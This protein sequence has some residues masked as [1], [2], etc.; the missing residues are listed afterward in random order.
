MSEAPAV[1]EHCVKVY[2]A[3]NRQA[4]D[5]E[6]NDDPI[7]GQGTVQKF[8]EGHTTRLFSELGLAAPYYTSVMNH[9]KRMG[10]VVQVR[11]GGGTAS[12]KWELLQEP[13]EELYNNM[14]GGNVNPTSAKARMDFLEKQV[15]D[16]YRRQQL[17]EQMMGVSL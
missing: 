8:W 11:R 2:E 12:S 16:L 4:V 17:I 6:L 14:L 13:T 1:Y 5:E 7:P 3:M 15:R 9:L 10:C